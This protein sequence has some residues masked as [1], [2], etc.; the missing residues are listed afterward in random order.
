MSTDSY[1]RSPWTGWVV[2]AAA[3]M[4]TIGALDIIQGLAALLKDDVFLVTGSG[5]L[6]TTDFTTWGWS[7]IIW[8]V[9][10][11]LAGLALFS[12]KEWGRWFAIV[13]M[14]DQRHRPDRVVPGLPAVEPGGDRPGDRRPLRP[15]RRLEG[16]EGGAEELR[17]GGRR[18]SSRPAP[19][20]WT[21][22]RSC[23]RQLPRSLARVTAP[24]SRGGRRP[25]L[26]PSSR[27][28]RRSTSIR[29]TDLHRP[30]RGA[31]IQRIGAV[32]GE[33]PPAERDRPSSYGQMR[34]S[35]RA[36]ATASSWEWHPRQSRIRRT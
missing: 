9:V 6:V 10:L 8:G 15:H 29:S 18:R 25:R 7:L 13:A 22:L 5:L 4:L 16:R 17:S 1:E 20:A 28:R 24:R 33:A 35:R 19:P 27:S 3:V 31:R 21:P 11:I 14:V 2:F 30:R 26:H 12:G 32:G 34:P 36:A 23:R